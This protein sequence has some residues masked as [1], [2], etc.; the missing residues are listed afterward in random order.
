MNLSKKRRSLIRQSIMLPTINLLQD[1]E[2]LPDFYNYGLDQC[3]FLLWFQQ[4]TCFIVVFMIDQPMCKEHH[5]TGFP[6]II[7]NQATSNMLYLDQSL[8]DFHHQDLYQCTNT[9]PIN[10]AYWF[11]SSINIHY[12][13][14]NTTFPK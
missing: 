1:N 13:I 4:A 12:R 2:Y 7:S 9:S 5:C 6:S 14:I 11:Q 3:S 8:L 10:P